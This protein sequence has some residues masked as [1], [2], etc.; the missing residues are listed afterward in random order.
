MMTN[1]TRRVAAPRRVPLTNFRFVSKIS[2]VARRRVCRV[3]L[4]LSAVRV[5]A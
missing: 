1:T 3:E 4:F 5:R 2:P